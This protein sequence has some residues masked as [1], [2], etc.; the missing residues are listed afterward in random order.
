MNSL[1][2]SLMAYVREGSYSDKSKVFAQ[3]LNCHDALM[4]RTV[5]INILRWA[6]LEH[7]RTLWIQ[8]GRPTKHK[9]MK[10]SYN[11]YPWEKYLCE[12]V[13]SNCEFHRLFKICGNDFLF[14]DNVSPEEQAELC[15]F[16]YQEFN[17][18]TIV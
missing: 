1:F 7:Q 8:Q 3:Q 14:A 9:P 12:L 18:Q 15:K 2:E 5:S 17:P 10:L 6:K 4:L 11:C 16:A 13:S